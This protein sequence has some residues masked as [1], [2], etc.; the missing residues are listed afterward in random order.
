MKTSQ[1][2]ELG[3]VAIEGVDLSSRPL[4]EEIRELNRLYD[5]H[6]L[7]VF[8]H[9]QLTKQQLVSAG[10]IF[11]GTQ[12]E[13]PAGQ[14]DPEAPGIFVISTR[15]EDG[16]T[17]PGIPKKSLETWNGTPIKDMWPHRTEEKYS[18]QCMLPKKEARRASSTDNPPT[19]PFRMT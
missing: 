10:S 5:E 2:S 7:V 16:K 4:P 18:I 8:R 3:G 14:S 17:V 13:R 15:G 11:G 19:I 1:L 9:Q 12:V 6:G